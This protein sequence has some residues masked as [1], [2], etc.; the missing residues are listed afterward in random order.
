MDSFSLGN[1]TQTTSMVMTYVPSSMFY[2][3]LYSLLFQHPVINASLVSSIRLTIDPVKLAY[4]LN[5]AYVFPLLL[6]FFFI[7]ILP[8]VVLGLL[9]L[10]Q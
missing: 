6:S 5:P 8:S 7:K 10:L 2:L 3:L 4:V 1:T 9:I